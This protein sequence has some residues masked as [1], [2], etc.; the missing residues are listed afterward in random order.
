MTDSPTPPEYPILEFDP[1]REAVIEPTRLVEPIGISEYSVPCFFE[2]VLSSL[3]ASGSA[4][5]VAVIK[6]ELGKRS[7][8]EVQF[9]QSRLVVFHPGV[10][11]PLAAISLEK[12]IALGCR[13]FV[14]CSGAGVLRGSLALGQIIVPTSCIRDEGTSYHYL[15]PS[16][17]VEVSP[18]AI[19]AIVRVLDAQRREYVKGKTWTTDALYRETEDRVRRRTS[20]GCLAVEMEAASLVAVARFRRVPLGYI[21]YAGDDV[22]HADWDGRRWTAQPEI[23]ETLFWL[24]AE[25]CLSMDLGEHDGRES[26]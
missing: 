10:G 11:G 24:A 9:D 5:E 20:E 1:S 14:A 3:H 8:Y 7:I 18:Q 25:A 15:P 23:R 12:V 4:K 26:P 13:R 22:S 16:R 19:D 21:M 17:E 2:D 6:T